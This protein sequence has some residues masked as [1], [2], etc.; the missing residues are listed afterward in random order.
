MET[1]PRPVPPEKLP[2]PPPPQLRHAMFLHFW[3][4]EFFKFEKRLCNGGQIAS[5]P[6]PEESLWEPF[7]LY[8]YTHTHTHKHTHTH[9]HTHTCSDRQKN[10]MGTRNHLFSKCGVNLVCF[11][12][13]FLGKLSHA[14]RWGVTLGTRGMAFLTPPPPHSDQI[15]SK[16]YPCPCICC[17][18]RQ[19]YVRQT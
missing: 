13:H 14:T 4:G 10:K 9:T 6:G 18:C 7:P 11:L 2:C 1:P 15:V 16:P 17:T 19:L 5:R 12:H 3:H 8:L